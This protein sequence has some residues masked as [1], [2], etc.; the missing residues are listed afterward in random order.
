MSQFDLFGCAEP[1][2][3]LFAAIPPEPP[4]P[5][6]KPELDAWTRETQRLYLANLVRDVPRYKAEGNEHSAYACSHNARGV[7]R[8]LN[9]MGGQ[10]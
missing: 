3:D 6:E 9:G 2:H 4:A 10:W 7:L 1:E 8:K 5:R